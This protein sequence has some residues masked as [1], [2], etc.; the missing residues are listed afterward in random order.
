VPKFIS[1]LVPKAKVLSVSGVECLS[2]FNLRGLFSIGKAL[3]ACEFDLLY[4]F[5]NDAMALL[6]FNGKSLCEIHQ[7]HEIIGIGNEFNKSFRG[8][9]GKLKL[10]IKSYLLLIGIKR[11]LFTFAV[12]KQLVEFFINKGVD[13]KKIEYLPHGVNLEIFDPDK[14]LVSARLNKV[15]SEKFA[16]V[17]TGWVSEKRGQKIMLDGLMALLRLTKNVHLI[18]VGC[19]KNQLVELKKYV[20]DH[21]MASNTTLFGRLDYLEMPEI[22]K[23]AN[24]CLSFLEPNASYS[25][26]PPQKIFEYFAMGKPVI[27]NNLPT[28]TDY[29][30]TDLNGIILDS[31]EVKNFTEAVLAMMKSDRYVEMSQCAL[32]SSRSYDIK[33]I[34]RRLFAKIEELLN[35]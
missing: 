20:D 31:L 8:F 3:N 12:S 7:S 17:Y 26:S 9:V 10:K 22:I 14:N 16:I 29:I 23:R 24:V 33:I 27:A 5:H 15:S 25:M 19:E 11:S 32:E 28:H 6:F 4:A 30:K 18:I 13:S 2:P 21:G 35:A 1:T 34:E